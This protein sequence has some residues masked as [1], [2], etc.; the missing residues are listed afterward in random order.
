MFVCVRAHGAYSCCIIMLLCTHVFISCTTFT[1]K[2]EDVLSIQERSVQSKSLTKWMYILTEDRED[3]E[4]QLLW[5]AERS[6]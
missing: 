3:E 5:Y 1:Q 4:K 6:Y 2:L